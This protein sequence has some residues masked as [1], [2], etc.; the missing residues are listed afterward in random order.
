MLGRLAS[1]NFERSQQRRLGMFRPKF[2]YSS[3]ERGTTDR[4]SRLGSAQRMIS[5]VKRSWR[6]AAYLDRHA[7]VSYALAE[8]FVKTF[9]RD[10]VYLADVWDA[11]TVLEL[12]PG[13]FEDYNEIHPHKGLKMMSPKEFRRA[14]SA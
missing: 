4:R 1:L 2:G 10:Y 11:E 3:I 12:I 9:K 14:R 5:S 8:A 6:G 13:W 7:N